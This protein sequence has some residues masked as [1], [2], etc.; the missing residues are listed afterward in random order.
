MD[1]FSVPIRDFHGKIPVL[2]KCEAWKLKFQTF[3]D[4][5]CSFNVI[6]F[7]GHS[8]RR[9]EESL[10]GAHALRVSAPTVRASPRIAITSERSMRT[11]GGQGGAPLGM[12]PPLG[13]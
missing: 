5:I 7:Q 11:F 10:L 12:P 3:F 13:E 2:E 8:F 1:L 6:N 4:T 9:I